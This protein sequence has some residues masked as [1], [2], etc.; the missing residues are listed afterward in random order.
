M[1][2]GQ[3]LV[4]VSHYTGQIH[5]PIQRQFFLLLSLA[6]AVLAGILESDRVVGE[7]WRSLT[8]KPKPRIW[9]NLTQ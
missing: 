2:L 5:F 7:V 3:R 9:G 8:E 1:K 4:R 6:I